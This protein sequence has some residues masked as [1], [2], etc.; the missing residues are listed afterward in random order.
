VV[1]AV[2]V[3]GL[4]TV[5]QNFRVEGISMEPTF[6]GGQALIVNRAAYVH[7]ENTPLAR[8]LPTTGQGSTKSG[9]NER[10][11]IERSRRKIKE[12]MARKQKK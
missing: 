5:V 10:K 7:I 9:K 1:T 11:Y 2:L 3:V 12:T 6:G 4:R 8:M